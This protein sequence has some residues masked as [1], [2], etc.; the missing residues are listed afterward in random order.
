MFARLR[1][2]SFPCC[3]AI[4][5][6]CPW[7]CVP[8]FSLRS[9]RRVSRFPS[10]LN[11]PTLIAAPSAPGLQLECQAFEAIFRIGLEVADDDEIQ[12]RE[13][14]RI[15]E[16]HAQQPGV[17]EPIPRK[18]SSSDDRASL[19]KASRIPSISPIGMPSERY[20][21]S[22][23]ASIRQTTLTGPPGIDDILEQPQHLVEHQEHRGEQQRADQGHGDGAP[24]IAVDQPH[25]RRNPRSLAMRRRL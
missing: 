9:I 20:S 21:G 23:L 8:F 11:S 14:D 16:G 19:R 7:S 4:R 22:K 5:R 6:K 25:M 10:R 17:A 13:R 15:S 24:E 18:A 3:P 2:R 12:R 1:R